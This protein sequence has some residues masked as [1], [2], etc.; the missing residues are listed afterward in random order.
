MENFPS[1]RHSDKVSEPE[2][3]EKRPAKLASVVTGKVIRRKTPLGKRVLETFF[4]R[5]NSVWQYL[6][7]EIL[8]PAAKDTVTDFVS[9]GV[10]R[11]VYGEARSTSRRTG[12]PGGQSNY[13][14]YNR[15][16]QPERR[17]DRTM[18]RRARASHDFQEIV[19]RTRAEADAVIDAMMDYMHKYEQ[20]TLSDLYDL[21][22]I[23]GTFADEKW[24]WRDLRGAGPTRI[25]EGY[26]LDLPRP[27]PLD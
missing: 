14:P 13:T 19:L 16:S 18:S 6:L 20:V 15:F 9:Q 17:Q 7:H 3:E 11:A 5:E 22:G 12:R 24:G 8:I 27:E 2:K 21:V 10:E 1:N 23:Q 25:N 4:G 26:L